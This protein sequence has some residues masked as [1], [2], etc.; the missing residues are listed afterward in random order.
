MSD[1]SASCMTERLERNLGRTKL[2]TY[3]LAYA[4]SSDNGFPG[5][6]PEDAQT[7][8][9]AFVDCSGAGLLDAM[10]GQVAHALNGHANTRTIA[11]VQATVDHRLAVAL[12]AA[13][14]QGTAPRDWL[15]ARMPAVFQRCQATNH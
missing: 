10:R 9:A 5:I 4:A 7:M 13:G 15:K 12:M 8:A 3:G 11:C 6:T 1:A 14:F 2:A